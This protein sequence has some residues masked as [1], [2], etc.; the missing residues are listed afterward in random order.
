MMTLLCIFAV[1]LLSVDAYFKD[2]M[3]FR[4]LHVRKATIMK[5]NDKA[6]PGSPLVKS[7][8]KER[9]LAQMLVSVRGDATS[10]A[11]QKSCE[12]YN[13]E[14]QERGYSVPGFRK[15][16]KLPAHYLYQMFGENNLKQLC[17]SL[18]AEEIQNECE[19]TGLMFVGRGRITD[20]RDDYFKAGEDHVIEIECDLWPAIKYKGGEKGYCGLIVEVVKSV[21]DR[22]K[23][24]SVKQNIRE[25]Y[26]ITTTTPKGYAANMGDVIKA[27]MHGYELN[28]FGT[29]GVALPSVASGDAVEI[30][31]EKGKF[32]DG[33]IEGLVGSKAGDEKSL[34]VVFPNRASGPGAVL[35]GQKAL[36][37]I[38]VLEVL[39]KEI[40]EWNEQLAAAIRDNM[41]L[42]ELEAEVRQAVEADE[43][44]S[45]DNARNDALANALIEVAEV[46]GLS[47]ALI[48]ENTQQR[49]QQ[50][51]VEFK[52]QGLTDEQL[53]KTMAPESYGKYKSMSR[54]NVEK[55]VKLGMIFRDISDKESIEVTA[56]EVDEQ[57]AMLRAQAKQKGKEYLDEMS[58]KD[59]IE[60]LL[61]R[62]KVFNFLA[63]K[64][65]ISYVDAEEKSQLPKG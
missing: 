37:E 1:G 39:K 7:I 11:F 22:E 9:N 35:S 8:D 65:T 48:E 55:V 57:M 63:S 58:A 49:F 64:A 10:R 17:R 25:R 32:M 27:N 28:A 3:V 19:L 34:K 20:F 24:E 18:L 31:L 15:G 40:P 52:E 41:T 26:K 21:F 46:K 14:V 51:I 54:P 4:A 13:K 45:V 5:A 23:Y 29:K 30:P 61:L 16:A 60:N 59:Q 44:S 43:Q 6:T 50:M 36:F 42:D 56:E 12:L 47:E 53:A 38:N 33:L 62:R 2:G